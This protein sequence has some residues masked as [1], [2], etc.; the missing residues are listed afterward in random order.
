MRTITFLSG[1]HRYYFYN[2]GAS[3]SAVLKDA[4]LV[5]IAQIRGMVEDSKSQVVQG[6]T[7]DFTWRWV[8]SMGGGRAYS[9]RIGPLKLE[10]ACLPGFYAGTTRTMPGTHTASSAAST[11]PLTRH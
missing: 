3:L 5:D 1:C 2:E 6:L 4:N 11:P 9:A 8:D 10:R 7:G